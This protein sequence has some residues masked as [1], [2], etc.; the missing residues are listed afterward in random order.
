MRGATIAIDL[1]GTLVDTAP[2]LIGAVNAVLIAEGLRPLSYEEGRPLI[3]RGARWML[4]SGLRYAGEQDPAG[5]AD[6][7]LGRFLDHY[8][9]HLSD[10]SRPFP[11]AV[12]ALE[13]LKAAGPKLVICTNKPTGLSR[14]LLTDLGIIDLF[15][16]VVG[17]DAVSALKPDAAH[18]IEAIAAVGGD[19]A[20][21]VMVGDAGPDAGVARAAGT[22]LILVSF[23]YS[24]TPAAD[25]A[26][27]ILLHHFDDLMEACA[28][29]LDATSHDEEN[30]SGAREG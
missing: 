4:Q 5:R 25:L 6:A 19:L 2:D 12:H 1:D 9:A 13:A 16:D 23:G 10:E 14:R 3:G 26:P 28:R 7:M 24:E 18:L 15:N 27:D 8:G 20:R 21:T 11:G 29:L 22:P 30:V 17:A